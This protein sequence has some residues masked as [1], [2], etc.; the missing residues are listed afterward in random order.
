MEPEVLSGPLGYGN[1]E[2]RITEVQRRDPFPPLKGQPDG[3]W[4]LHFESVCG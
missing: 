4:C 3:L 1:V 2:I